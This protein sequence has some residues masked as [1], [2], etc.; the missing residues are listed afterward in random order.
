MADELERTSIFESALRG[1]IKQLP[2][3]VQTRIDGWQNTLTSLGTV[4]D[5]TIHT[6]PTVFYPL[7]DQALSAMFHSDATVRKAMTKRVRAAL[8]SGFQVSVPDDDGGA[9]VG[10]EIQEA[11]DV[12]GVVNAFVEAVTWSQ[13]FGGCVIYIGADDGY[14]GAD[15]QE[16]EL[17]S[18]S[19]KKLLWLKVIDRRYVQRP[20][21]LEG[22]DMDATSPHFGEP[23]YYEVNAPVA[24]GVLRVKIHR[25][26]LIV[27]KGPMTSV[28]EREK[29]QGWGISALDP[30]YDALQ[31]SVNAWASAGN[32]VANAQYTVYA[33]KGLSQMLGTQG[34]EDKM[35]AR[36]KA[37][38]M[39]KSMINAI[40][41]DADDKYTR[42]KIDF[43]NLP[44]M[45]D[46]FMV[47][48]ASAADIPVAELFETSKGG[49]SDTGEGSR[50]R[51]EASVTELRE[52]ELRAP[53]QHIVELIMA[54]KE[55]P[56][57]G[58]V[59]EGWRVKFHPLEMLGALE[60]ADRYLKVATA[61]GVYLT[62]QVVL[63]N[64]IATSRFRAEGYSTDTTI[65]LEA[66]ELM[67]QAEVDA[68][69]AGL[70]QAANPEPVEAKGK[71]PVP[72]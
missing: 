10:T 3:S 16:R 53:L 36:S 24:G 62:N 22:F 37:M 20:T 39:A 72:E 6:A 9:E 57:K 69:A 11:A 15:S 18:E 64:E 2:T 23:L 8:R 34:G 31:R 26:R 25:S 5:K 60:E 71:D 47:D 54:S 21:T 28:D 12:L 44:E 66:R 13:L 1:F 38:E 48:V 41:I 46:R 50:E 58:K 67:A 59:L 4:S 35:K 65:D 51:W 49:L 40:L 7:N 63:P 70:E 19:L 68:R 33:L 52:H 61:D 55:G 42:E 29:R 14:K 17:K 43:G 45:L 27:F 32:A 30:V 56:T